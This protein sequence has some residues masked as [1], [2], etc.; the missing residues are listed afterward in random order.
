[1]RVL[2]LVLVLLVSAGCA[3]AKKTGAVSAS[4]SASA[5]AAPSISSSPAATRAAA[6]SPAP[7]AAVRGASP[8]PR[9]DASRNVT[10]SEAAN[11]KTITVR[12]RDEVTAVLHSTYW[13]FNNPSDQ[14]VLMAE[15]DPVTSPQPGGCVPGQGCGTV[16]VRYLAVGVGRTVVSAHR[17][18][19]GEAMRCTPAASDWRVTVVVTGP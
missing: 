5:S 3:S 2:T 9:P 10:V 15:G 4:P 12:R 6:V 16:T 13:K 17:D 1:M 14:R 18:T 8:S 11:G 7:T 19:C